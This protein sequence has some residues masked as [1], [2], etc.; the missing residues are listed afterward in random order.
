MAVWGADTDAIKVQG[1]E[2]ENIAARI[3]DISSRIKKAGYL[4]QLEFSGKYQVQLSVNEL[5]RSIAEQSRKLKKMG[6]GLKDVAAIYERTEKEIQDQRYGVNPFT[7]NGGNGGG[8]GGGGGREGGEASENNHSAEQSYDPSEQ[9]IKTILTYL[10]KVEKNKEAG[11]ISKIREY[12]KSLFGFWNGDQTGWAGLSAWCGLSKKSGDLWS[13]FYKYCKAKD[14]SGLLEKRFGKGAAQVAVIGSSLGLMGKLANAFGSDA[15]NGWDKAADFLDVGGSG[16]GV[17]QSVYDLKHLADKGKGGL[18]SPASLWTTTAETAIASVSQGIRSIGAYSADGEWDMLDTGATG[19]D[20]SVA[21][22]EKM[23]SKLTF[24]MVSA[25]TFGTSPGQI[26]QNLKNWAAETGTRAGNYIKENP[27]LQN[28]YE[29]GN[30]FAQ[31]G[32]TCYATVAS[33]FK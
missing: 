3:Q 22:L 25:E 19:V 10:D 29:K 28:A 17:V 27:A 32:I 5:S 30:T 14:P 8:A 18:Y 11:L 7:R 31:V 23:V 4:N 33:L 9:L 26:S 15:E 2:L 12:L 13:G 6:G 1:G 21:G 16:A 24:G 20:A